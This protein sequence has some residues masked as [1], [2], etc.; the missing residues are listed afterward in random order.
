MSSLT[1]CLNQVSRISEAQRGSSAVPWSQSMAWGANLDR[2]KTLVVADRKTLCIVRNGKCLLFVSSQHC[3][4]FQRRSHAGLTEVPVQPPNMKHGRPLALSRTLWLRLSLRCGFLYDQ[5][6]VTGRRHTDKLQAQPLEWTG[7]IADRALS[8][9]AH[10][11]IPGGVR[12]IQH[13]PEIGRE[14]QQ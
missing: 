2:P 7:P 5:R 6:G 1:G 9:Q 10:G 13:P 12:A 8:E 3:L 14:R 4:T 11:R